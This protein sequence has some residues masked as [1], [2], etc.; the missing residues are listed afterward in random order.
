VTGGY[1]EDDSGNL[2]ANTVTIGQPKPKAAAP[3]ASTA[4][5]Q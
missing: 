2:V 5:P 4:A 3:A 1:H